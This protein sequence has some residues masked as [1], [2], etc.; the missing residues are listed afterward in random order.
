VT[1]AESLVLGMAWRR[2]YGDLRPLSFREPERWT[3][4]ESRGERA[5]D[6]CRRLL[7]PKREDDA[8]VALLDPVERALFRV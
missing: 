1:E 7:P 8:L 2:T 4:P 3:V 5:L 6:V